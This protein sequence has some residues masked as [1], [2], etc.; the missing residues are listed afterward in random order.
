MQEWSIGEVLE[1]F[2]GIN[3]KDLGHL[4][5]LIR[6]TSDN[7][8]KLKSESGVIG[9]FEKVNLENTSIIYGPSDFLK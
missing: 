7:K 5:K 1:S 3:I 6:D 8:A 2:N 4:L 9:F